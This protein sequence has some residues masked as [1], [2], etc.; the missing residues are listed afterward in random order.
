M[1]EVATNGALP[2]VREGVGKHW[3]LVRGRCP[4]CRLSSL[5]LAAGG[6]ITCASLTCS[7]PGAA[8]DLLAQ[9]TESEAR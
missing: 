4:A 8:S 6:Y 7:N 2:L 3:P 9:P 5:F 1:H